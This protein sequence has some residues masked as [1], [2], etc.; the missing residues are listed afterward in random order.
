MNEKLFLELSLGLV[1][2]KGILVGRDH[3]S[4]EGDR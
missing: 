3:I 4:D 1:V 2:T